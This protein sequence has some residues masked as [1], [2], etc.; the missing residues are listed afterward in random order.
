[1]FTTFSW[2]HHAHC[3]YLPKSPIKMICSKFKIH[4][5]ITRTTI[6]YFCVVSFYTK[7]N[8]L[9]YS[10]RVWKKTY[11]GHSIFEFDAESDFTHGQEGPRSASVKLGPHLH[12]HTFV[13][14]HRNTNVW[15]LAGKM[16]HVRIPSFMLDIVQVCWKST[17]AYTI[18]YACLFGYYHHRTN[19][20]CCFL[21][22]CLIV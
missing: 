17:A 6:N 5:V 11:T 13:H 14:E 8:S 16:K 15:T 7:L 22:T 1:M 19:V 9:E 4:E 21:N 20:W 12:N 10:F 18:I 2:D 3:M